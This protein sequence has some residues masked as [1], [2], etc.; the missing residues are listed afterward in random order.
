MSETCRESSPSSFSSSSSSSLS[1]SSRKSSL[2]KKKL[3]FGSIEIRDIPMELGNHPPTA[4][5]APVTL[6]WQFESTR[7]THIDVYELCKDDEPRPK[8]EWK[9]SA[10]DRT[11]ILL[12]AGYSLSDI[13]EASERAEETMKEREATLRGQWLESLHLTKER[14]G[15]KLKKNLSSFKNASSSPSS[16][17][18]V[19]SAAAERAAE[20][21]KDGQA[22]LRGQWWESLHLAKERVGS[23]FKIVSSSPSTKRTV[24]CAAA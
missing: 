1:S 20:T 16:K 9:L 14:T 13:H 4:G 15:R 2:N 24:S 22:T 11:A 17:R 8:H 23:S 18:T 19:P 12:R 3:R 6:G 7:V 21:I 10:S 5:G